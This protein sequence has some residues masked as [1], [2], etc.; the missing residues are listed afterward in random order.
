M[1]QI[2]NKI[3]TQSPNYSYF[4]LSHDHKTTLDMGQL[5]PVNCM[6]VVPGDVHTIS[7]Q[8]LFRMSPMIAPIMHKVDVTIH[9][10]FVPN[11]LVWRNWE[12]F[13]SPSQ[14]G[15]P[16]PVSPVYWNGVSGEEV[17]P[18]SLADR[19]GIPV[20]TAIL[21]VINAIPFAAYQRIWWD[22]YRDQNLQYT[23]IYDF[24]AFCGLSDG[25]Q[26][27]PDK[28]MRLK[29]LRYRAWEHDYF[30]S[31]LPFAQK[32]AAVDIPIEVTVGVDIPVNFEASGSPAVIK[33]VDG[34]PFTGGDTAMYMPLGGGAVLGDQFSNMVMLDNSSALRAQGTASEIASFTTI[35]DLRASYAL[36]RFLERNARSGT[37]YTEVILA[38][39]GVRSS[40]A[41]LQ[42]AEYL[43]GSKSVMAISEV[44]STAQT[45]SGSDTIP[46]GNMSGH[47]I[48]VMGGNSIRYFAEEHGF[49]ISLC[50]IRP[51]SSYYQ[52]LPRLFSRHTRLDYLWPDF[53][54]LGEQAVLNKEIFMQNTSPN[55][56]DETFGYL[57]RYT[58]YRYLPS[59][60]S[61]DFQTYLKPWG[62]QRE[63]IDPPALNDDFIKCIP[64]SR[65]FAVD[66]Y[67]PGNP[68]SIIAHIFNQITSKR[69]LPK[70]GN[71]GSL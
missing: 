60:V 58:E 26:M 18:G 11:R 57:P 70:Y 22:Y 25:P 43:G 28:F 34:T 1:S 61:A 30:T 66:P 13:I 38:N 56:N 15:Q 2:F 17:L 3:Q 47:G 71:P 4:D 35:N 27:D 65:I 69:P 37:R 33:N 20:T 41:R 10:F 31:A 8:A 55:T 59:R 23:D 45:G 54:F 6:E 50:S 32:G 42:R 64:S 19:L 24:E 63:F 21:P 62:L 39:F 51:K 16:E 67:T 7:S 9:H 46:Q 44:L 52:G 12:S 29:E 68:Q 36:Q 53:S 14:P 40:D 49:I 48:S 5:I